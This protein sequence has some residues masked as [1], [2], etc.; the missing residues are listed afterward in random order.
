[1]GRLKGFGLLL[2]ELQDAIHGVDMGTIRY[3]KNLV[4]YIRPFNPKFTNE[5]KMI[6]IDAFISRFS[7]L[8]LQQDKQPWQIIRDLPAAIHLLLAT[9][10]N[11]YA[12]TNGIA[13][14][15]TAT[16]EEGAVLK[17]P[18]II[19]KNSFIAAHAYLRGGVLIDDN[20]T[21]GTG[22]EIKSSIICNNSSIAHF[23]FIGDSIIGSFVNIEAGAITANHF[24]ERKNKEIQVIFKGEL[25]NTLIEKFGSL[26]G[27]HSKIGA[28]AVLSPGTLLPKNTVVKRLEL[29]EQVV[30]FETR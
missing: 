2:K 3:H 30:D 1:M 24:N 23:N 15:T 9:C 5:N 8:M 12:V 26:I 13:I 22:C 16:V 28:N 21:I 10:G 19:G 17:A 25:I 18:A 27:D 29:I 20:V 6:P 4:N 11:D 7:S 14:H